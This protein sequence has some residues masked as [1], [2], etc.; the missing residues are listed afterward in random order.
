MEACLPDQSWPKRST[1]ITADAIELELLR[2]FGSLI[3]GRKYSWSSPVPKGIANSSSI[4]STV[5]FVGLLGE[6]WSGGKA[7]SVLP[8]P[9]HFWLETWDEGNNT[10]LDIGGWR[11]VFLT[12]V[13]QRAP[14]KLQMTQS[15]CSWQGPL[16]VWFFGSKQSWSSLLPKDLANSSSIASAVIFVGLLGKYWSEGKATSVLLSSLH[17]WLK[18]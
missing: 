18:T 9:L 13:D 3:Y 17:F 2:L 14:Q 6:P 16:V 10:L 4:A 12:G 1:K 7:T 8:S 11:H 15:N 5:I